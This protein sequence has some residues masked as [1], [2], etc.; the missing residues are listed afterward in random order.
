MNNATVGFRHCLATLL[1]T[2]GLLGLHGCSSNNV[3]TES[4][5]LTAEE[6]SQIGQ[7]VVLRLRERYRDTRSECPPDGNAAFYCNGVF[8]RALNSDWNSPTFWNPVDKDIERKGVS[9]I[10]MRVDAN[11]EEVPGEAGIIMSEMDAHT[12]EKLEVGCAFPI[13]AQT[14]VRENSCYLPNRP[15]SCQKRR[16]W[17]AKS[18]LAYY[19]NALDF[20]CYFEPTTRWFQLSIEIRRD[21]ADKLRGYWNEVIIR[22]WAQDIPERLPLEALWYNGGEE[23]L[24]HARTMQDTFIRATGLFIP[25]VRIDPSHPDVFFYVPRDQSV[26]PAKAR[27]PTEAR[28]LTGKQQS[29][30]SL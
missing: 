2:L 14:N 4:T 27:K 30:A 19:E 24:M 17:D 16:V 1:I 6:K 23:G 21:H 12:Q 28:A 20:V 7:S 22:P 26:L 11:I 9:F 13:N 10:Y 15:M 5:R 3:P 18:W 25:I 8:V 29:G